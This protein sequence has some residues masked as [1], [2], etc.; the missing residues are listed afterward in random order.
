MQQRP[1]QRINII[2]S[3]CAGKSTFAARLAAALDVPHIELDALHWEP[4]WTEVSWDV[5]RSR[6][7][8]A[9]TGEAWVADGNYSKARDILW[10]RLDTIIW[11]DYPFALV[12]WRAIRRTLART[13]RGDPCCNGN[14]E[15]LRRTFSRDS[16]LLWVIQTHRSKQQAMRKLL[17]TLSPNG[18]R[19]IILRTPIAAERWLG[20]VTQQRS[21]HVHD[22]KFH[23]GAI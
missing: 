18:P 3:S 8:D 19:V 23:A 2:G 14:R 21:Y 17:P 22:A 12:L 6:V 13:L 9:T 11:L 20:R 1:M 10:P 7:A 5:F 16:I 4:G 15:S